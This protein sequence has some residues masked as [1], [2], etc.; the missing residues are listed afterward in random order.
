MFV[1]VYNIFLIEPV[2]KLDIVIM[3]HAMQN[4]KD[5]HYSTFS[6]VFNYI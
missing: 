4:F 6:I 2:A 5:W 1:N 3:G